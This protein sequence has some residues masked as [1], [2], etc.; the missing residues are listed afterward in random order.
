MTHLLSTNVTNGTAFI[1]VSIII[2]VVYINTEGS[3]STALGTWSLIA[4]VHI[5]SRYISS[6]SF[7][8]LDVLEGH[9]RGLEETQNY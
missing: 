9:V 6:Q 1:L 5:T 7:K 8:R 2:L 4:R 3:K